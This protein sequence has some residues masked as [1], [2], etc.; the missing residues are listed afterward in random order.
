MGIFDWLFGKKNKKETEQ[1]KKRRINQVLNKIENEGFLS[2]SSDEKISLS[3]L[4]F[5]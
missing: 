1:D 5:S 2:L 4:C 3:L